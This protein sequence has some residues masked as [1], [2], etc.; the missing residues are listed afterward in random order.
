MSK[1]ITIKCPCGAVVNHITQ[2]DTWPK[3]KVTR[4]STR[5]NKCKKAFQYEVVGGKCTSWYS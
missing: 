4:R 3:D 5:C 1:V 2:P